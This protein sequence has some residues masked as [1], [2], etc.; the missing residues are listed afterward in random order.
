[1][2]LGNAASCGAA[3]IGV[4]VDKFVSRAAMLMVQLS[5]TSARQADSVVERD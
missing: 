2:P 3:V 5:R 4:E 1:M